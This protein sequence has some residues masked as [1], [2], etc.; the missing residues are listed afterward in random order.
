[1]KLAGSI[2]FCLSAN[3]QSRELPANAAMAN[4]VRMKVRV[5][6]TLCARAIQRI[7][8]LSFESGERRAGVAPG[9]AEARPSALHY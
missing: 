2:E 1:M 3:R 7:E 9:R 5:V 4:N 8:S 6:L